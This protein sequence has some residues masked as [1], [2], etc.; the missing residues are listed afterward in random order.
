MT[1]SNVV[2]LSLPT[3]DGPSDTKG[4]HARIDAPSAVLHATLLQAACAVV[5]MR[6]GNWNAEDILA[7]CDSL[8]GVCDEIRRLATAQ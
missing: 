8:T 6:S 1:E 3:R 5:D 7:L 2:T 4:L